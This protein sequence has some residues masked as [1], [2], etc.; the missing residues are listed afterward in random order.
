MP[1]KRDKLAERE[2]DKHVK[3]LLDPCAYAVD[4]FLERYN[5]PAGYMPWNKI[6]SNH[7]R[8]VAKSNKIHKGFKLDQL[9]EKCDRML[10]ATDQLY[11]LPAYFL[12]DDLYDSL[13]QT[14][15][16]PELTVNNPP[17]KIANSF[18]LVN[19]L[20][21][22]RANYFHVEMID[23]G[24]IGYCNIR[25]NHSTKDYIFGFRWGLDPHGTFSPMDDDQDFCCPKC[26]EGLHNEFI[27]LVYNF[28]LLLNLQPD[29]V[30]Q[31]NIKA[32]TK[33]RGFSGS[34]SQDKPKPAYWV[35]K[36]FNKRIVKTI[37][38]TRAIGSNAPKSSH[39]RRGHWHT[40]SQGPGRKQKRMK[41][42]QPTFIVGNA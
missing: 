15:I 34:P 5:S 20:G 27:I 22:D 4:R 32:S 40:V 11:T 19:S 17:N 1:T 31:E 12:T 35:G 37:P 23:G 21:P 30:S 6:A 9:K 41:W 24:V 39:W 14:D 25:Q 42:F 3:D 7:T 2:L 26:T 36:E 33:G 18:F 28:I 38:L 8:N 10:Q 13:I 16:K 29:I